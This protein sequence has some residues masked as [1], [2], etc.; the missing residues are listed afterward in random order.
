MEVLGVTSYGDLSQFAQQQSRASAFILSID[1]EEFSARARA[2]TRPWSTCASSSRRSAS[3][4]GDP[5]LP[6]RR[7]AHV[8]HI[9]NDILRELHGF[10]HMFEDTPEFV[11]RHIIREARSYLDSLA[12]P[13]FRALV[14][15][16]SDGSYSWHCPGHSGGVAFLKSPVGQMFHQFF[17]ENMLRADVC[18]SVDELGQLLDHSGPGRG[19][20]AQRGAHL[21]RRRPVLRHQRHVDVEQD[22]VARDRRAGRRRRRRPQLPRVDPARDHDDRRDPRVP[23][24]DAQQPRHHRPDSRSTSSAGRTSRRRS[25]RIRSRKDV[26]T[27]PRILTITQSTYDGVLYN[28]DTIKDLLATHDRHAAFRRG[29]AAARGVPRVL[30][31]H[32]RDRPRPAALEGRADLRD[33]VDAQAARGAVAG[34]ADPRAGLARRASST[35]TASTRRT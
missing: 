15:Y 8:A 7:D 27:K 20:R 6:V 5:D 12:P 1:D 33:A 29:V 35:R 23:D 10:I 16:A 9:P 11:A 14:H 18:N 34:V 2:T 3:E 21:Q 30:P 31:G 4:L 28:V 25:T 19:V 22:G 26:K 24:A 13:F 32:A 17:G